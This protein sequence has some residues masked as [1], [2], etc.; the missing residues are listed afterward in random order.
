MPCF[1]LVLLFENGVVI[2]ST[3]TMLPLVLVPTSHI[4]SFVL[5]GVLCVSTVSRIY[6]L[7][8]LTL[9]LG[10]GIHFL[11]CKCFLLRP[12]TLVTLKVST[13]LWSPLASAFCFVSPPGLLL[14]IKSLSL[15]KVSPLSQ[16][17]Q[18]CKGISSLSL[19]CACPAAAN[20]LREAT[21]EL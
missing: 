18:P 17:L 12:P 9:F 14:F 4:P 5:A 10:H 13:L 15:K 3:S 8:I 1:R 2:R 11:D 7:W 16:D 19:L 6:L 20:D 21:G